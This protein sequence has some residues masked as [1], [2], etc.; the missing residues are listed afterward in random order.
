MPAWR[1]LGIVAGGGELPIALAEHCAATGRDFYVARIS[2]YADPPLDVFP[3]ATHGLGAMGA[4]IA[5]L[6][7]AGCDAIVFVGRVP[8]PD[9]AL[10]EWD[11]GARA[12]LPA[13]SEAA[14]KGDDEL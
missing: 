3:G 14:R 6:Q 7:Q 2:P 8:R 1:K 11:D 12:M 4:R 10:M 13:L 9:F 5:G